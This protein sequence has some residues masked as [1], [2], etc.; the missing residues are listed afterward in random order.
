MRF[1]KM[2]ARPLV[3]SWSARDYVQNGLVAMWDGIEDAGWGIHDPNATTW[4]DLVG[5]NDITLPS[6]SGMYFGDSFLH[7]GLSG[8]LNTGVD[9]CK[10]NST[11]E[12]LIDVSNENIASENGRFFGS[13]SVAKRFEIDSYSSVPSQ[14]PRIYY[15]RAGYSS[16]STSSGNF[17]RSSSWGLWS[18]RYTIDDT[19]TL[20]V[21]DLVSNKKV[22][23]PGSLD[24]NFYSGVS[25]L[26]GSWD[27]NNGPL[28]SNIY[29]VRRYN[30]VL[31][32]DEQAYNYN[33]D[34]LRFN[35][36]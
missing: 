15:R 17:G 35:L 8:I 1:G 7:R 31:T 13:S 5:S 34:K 14:A 9:V 22:S 18:I 6:G 20:E 23:L 26:L 16:N 25:L 2:G 19:G 4:K 12:M 3:K 21:S 24:K 36:P 29:S 27:N 33:I 10:F 28:I 30:K 32:S 11:T